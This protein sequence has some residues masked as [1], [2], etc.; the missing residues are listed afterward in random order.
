LSQDLEL[1]LKWLREAAEREC[2]DA[3][4]QLGYAYFG[5]DRG[6]QVDNVMALAWFRKAALQGKALL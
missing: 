4:F 1:S 3:Q 2:A 5:G 6:L